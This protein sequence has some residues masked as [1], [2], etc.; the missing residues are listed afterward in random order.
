MCGVDEE[1]DEDQVEG[2]AITRWIRRRATQML[3]WLSR[4]IQR[5][6][7]WNTVTETIRTS[8]VFHILAIFIVLTN[9]LGS[10]S[11]IVMGLIR[12]LQ[13]WS[14]ITAFLGVL[15][16]LLWRA[17]WNVLELG[18]DLRRKLKPQTVNET[19]EGS[20]RSAPSSSR[21]PPSTS[22]GIGAGP[23]RGRS[24]SPTRSPSPRRG[25]SAPSSPRRGPSLTPGRRQ[26]CTYCGDPSHPARN[27]PR[28]PKANIYWKDHAS[29]PFTDADINMVSH[30]SALESD[31][32]SE[33][34]DGRMEII[35]QGHPIHFRMAV[36]VCF[37]G[38]GVSV[39]AECSTVLPMSIVCLSFCKE[40]GLHVTG[41]HTGYRFVC[42]D[43]QWHESVGEATLRVETG[44]AHSVGKFLVVKP[45]VP[46]HLSC[47]TLRSLGI[48][49]NSSQGRV[50][51][52]ENQTVSVRFMDSTD[53]RTEW[54]VASMVPSM[55]ESWRIVNLQTNLA[56]NCLMNDRSKPV[57]HL[58][59]FD[60]PLH[61]LK[62]TLRSRRD[63]MFAFNAV[64]EQVLFESRRPL[65]GTA[66]FEEPY[67]SELLFACID[68][69][70]AFSTVSRSYCTLRRIQ[71]HDYLTGITVHLPNMYPVQS[72]GCASLYLGV[73]DCWIRI[74]AVV[75][76]E[77]LDYVVFGRDV[78]SAFG[79]YR[80]LLQDELIIMNGFPIPFCHMDRNTNNSL[81][82]QEVPRFE[83]VHMVS[84][85]T[86]NA[87]EDEAFDRLQK[88]VAEGSIDE[89]SFAL[90]NLGSFIIPITVQGVP[91]KLA[92][93]LDTGSSVSIFPLS[94][95]H[96]LDLRYSED[97]KGVRLKGFSGSET[98]SGSMTYRVKVGT[99]T[100]SINFIVAPG[101]S[102]IILGIPALSAFGITLDCAKM[103]TKLGEGEEVESA[104]SRSL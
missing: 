12:Y 27:C 89:S 23:S 69:L 72:I 81:E 7:S 86:P 96:E 90:G 35:S 45:S 10:S 99:V 92:A 3:G 102:I 94:G 95:V 20:V 104:R 91:L 75:V 43:G 19:M 2:A 74:T 4:Q 68:E 34:D 64:S 65:M 24:A 82:A 14:E 56:A 83:N 54:Q 18:K 101:A 100:R 76:E 70:Q 40:H 85:E 98:S 73:Q 17:C 21:G 46:L 44:A 62:E 39:E 58:T 67:N 84:T 78:V 79:M 88:T 9:L 15:V 8:N 93:L 51:N 37:R 48:S 41:E 55:V 61:V 77:A 60:G 28:R 97:R 53:A 36:R 29:S 11:R 13:Q 59:E 57:S 30:D 25:T 38:R 50:A 33:I 32:S 63:I 80:S 49:L 6:F 42:N 16:V 26:S 66:F 87:D 71:T 1:V 31:Y 103:C 22:T 52:A 5:V 47:H